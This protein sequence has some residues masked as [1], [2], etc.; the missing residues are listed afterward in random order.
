MAAFYVSTTNEA[1]ESSQFTDE[2]VDSWDNWWKHLNADFSAYMESLPK[3][4]F[5]KNMKFFV[6]NGNHRR[7]AWMN[8][9][10]RLYSSDPD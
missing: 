10:N 8:H 5:M 2:E 1:G 4:N 6:C 3:L 7:I 9:I